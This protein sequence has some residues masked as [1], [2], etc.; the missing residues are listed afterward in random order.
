MTDG[1]TYKSTVFICFFIS[2]NMT[3]VVNSR[4]KRCGKGLVNRIINKLPVELHIPGYQ[5]CGPGTKLSKRL[6]RGDPG[7]NP[8]DAACKEH[9]IAYSQNR[10]N[11]TARN[12][13]DQVLADK[14]WNRVLARDASIGEKA[15][16]WG[17]TNTM[18]A[19]ARLGMGL[20]K[21][22][23]GSTKRR[24]SKKKN[25]TA[26][27]KRRKNINKC[28]K[29]LKKKKK[30]PLRQI[31]QAA[32]ASIRPGDAIKSA[33]KG[34]REAVKKAGGKKNIRSPRILP[35]PI[36]IGG[37]LPFLIPIFAGLS[38]TG[39][40]AGGAAGIA[41]A[42]N[43]AS[44]AKRKLEESKRHNQTMESIALGKGL[45]LNPYKSGFGLHL[46]PYSKNA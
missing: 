18:K 13:A 33:L 29:G 15:A 16:A 40:L 23:K 4:H 22:G 32:K 11:I 8:L 44:A 36:K 5:Y 31:I 20:K 38:A 41:K 27:K 39:A 21:R 45:H 43:D 12:A 34:A 25:S 42:V 7:I 14:A 24:N 35:V 46:K 30:I 37:F 3:I 2:H 26:H 28:G 17:V 10:D 6:A 19:K 9:D 1:K